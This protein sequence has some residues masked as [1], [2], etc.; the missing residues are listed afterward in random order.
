LQSTDALVFADLSSPCTF[1]WVSPPSRKAQSRGHTAT[2]PTSPTRTGE[3]AARAEV[4]RDADRV[5]GRR[6]APWHRRSCLA[7]PISG[8]PLPPRAG[9]AG[10]RPPCSSSS[11]P[12]TSQSSSS[13]SAAASAAEAESPIRRPPWHPRLPPRPLVPLPPQGWSHLPVLPSR[14]WVFRSKNAC[15]LGAAG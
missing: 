9:A 15:E 3:R 14:P 1:F 7:A 4:H 6:D 5:A 10:P 2:K 11:L 8:G 13:A 12:L